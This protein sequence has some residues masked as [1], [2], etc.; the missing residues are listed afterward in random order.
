M[1]GRLGYFHGCIIN[2]GLVIFLCI[3]APPVGTRSWRV[4]F[5]F[6]HGM[7]LLAQF[8]LARFSLARIWSA[9]LIT[10][11]SILLKSLAIVLLLDFR[12]QSLECR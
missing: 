2:R 12:L 3:V 9:S 11:K 10:A 5:V 4:R 7:P 1:I 6:F 8:S